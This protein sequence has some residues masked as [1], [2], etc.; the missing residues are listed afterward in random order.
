MV[1]QT[2]MTY[3]NQLT[4][5]ETITKELHRELAARVLQYA[6]VLRVFQDRID[7]FPNVD[8]VR[9]KLGQ[10]DRVESEAPGDTHNVIVEEQPAVLSIDPDDLLAMT[11]RLDEIAQQLGFGADPDVSPSGGIA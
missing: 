6:D 3:Y 10:M 11:D 7:D 2:R 9:Q 4:R 8:H 5:Q 1:V